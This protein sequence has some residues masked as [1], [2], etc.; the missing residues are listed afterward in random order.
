MNSAVVVCPRLPWPPVTGGQKRT[1]R[2][3]E[4]AERAGAHPHLLTTDYV[5]EA[6]LALEER[7]WA[8]ELLEPPTST[9]LARP[10]Q[11]L[12]RRPSPF[13][14]AIAARVRELGALRPAFVQLEHTQS[15]YYRVSGGP[16]TLLSLH[17]LDSRLHASIARRRT[18]GTWSWLRAWNRAL[19]TRTV[20]RRAFPAASRVICVSAD[21]AAS[22]ERHGGSPLL[23]PNGIDDSFF[24]V[25]PGA[26]QERVM[27]F[28]HFG[29]EPNRLGLERFL[30]KGWPE[31]RRRRPR[32]QLAVAGS[33]LSSVLRSRL[34]AEPGVMALGLV[35]DLCEELAAARVVVAPI[36]E[37]AGTRLKVL[38]ALGAARPVAATP[39]GAAGLDVGPGQGVELAEHPGALGGAVA[40][41]LAEPERAERLGREGRRFVERFR[42]ERTL[43]ELEELY[44]GYVLSSR[45]EPPGARRESARS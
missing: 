34:G 45:S 3:L 41:L 32:A 30:S 11:L 39:L 4:A 20:E 23:A 35:E 10:R 2:L 43:V 26:P 19:A 37:G 22:V 27:F 17:N 14:P 15:A 8:V 24:S 18:P 21:E 1:L 44:R 29:Y 13:L 42:W 6:A 25:V 33:G 5:P 31:V 28:G 16:P 36:W 12:A 40:G 38:E 9:A 7:G